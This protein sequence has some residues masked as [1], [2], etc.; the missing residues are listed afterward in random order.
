M[1]DIKKIID[2]LTQINNQSFLREKIL[3]ENAISI[4][5]DIAGVMMLAAFDVPMK[6]EPATTEQNK[7][8]QIALFNAGCSWGSNAEGNKVRSARAYL[9]CCD[10][11]LTGADSFSPF[12]HDKLTQVFDDS[13]N[14]MVEVI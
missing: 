6:F 1:N 10:K 13:K 3:N 8:I 2:T 5:A 11:T 7:L 9:F 4:K 14:V 12:G